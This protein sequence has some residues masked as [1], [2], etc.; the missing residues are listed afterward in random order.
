MNVPYHIDIV[1]SIYHLKHTSMPSDETKESL[2]EAEAN[3]HE[4]AEELAE[5]RVQAAEEDLEAVRNGGD[6]PNDDDDEDDSD[7]EEGISL[8]GTP[9]LF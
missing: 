4:A 2:K 8:T 1:L 7:E 3:E 6:L 5:T 9:G